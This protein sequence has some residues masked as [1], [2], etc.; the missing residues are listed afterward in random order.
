MG[1]NLV[2]DRY[3]LRPLRQEDAEITLRWRNA[4]SVRRFMYT[5]HLIGAAEHEAWIARIL[6][7]PS[8]AYFLF[9]EEG[10][11]IGNVGIYGIHPQNRSAEWNFHL[12]PEGATRGAGRAMEFFALDMAFGELSLR[13][14]VCEVLDF[15]QRVVEMHKS[16]GFQQEGLRKRHVLKDGLWRDVH[17]LALFDEDWRAGRPRMRAD[18]FA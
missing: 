12:R 1:L 5:D 9:E 6:T 4:E 11:P 10:E 15:N 18:V 3:R 14:L 8:K 13:K 7:D 2:F 16:F 17:E